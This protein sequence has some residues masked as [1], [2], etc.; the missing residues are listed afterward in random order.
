MPPNTQP[1]DHRID[2]LTRRPQY[3]WTG[4]PRTD[5]ILI[6]PVAQLRELANLAQDGLLT[7]EEHQRQRARV[8]NP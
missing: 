4:E 8:L 1:R 5:H 3:G 2:L 6:D 7:P